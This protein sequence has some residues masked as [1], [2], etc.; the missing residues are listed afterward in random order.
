MCK[1]VKLN[2]NNLNDIKFNLP[3]RKYSVKNI[4]RKILKS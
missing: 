3:S 2:K 4:L 1:I